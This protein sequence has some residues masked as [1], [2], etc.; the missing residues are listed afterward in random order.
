M[1]GPPMATETTAVTERPPPGGQRTG[2]AERA[3]I[4]TRLAAGAL[5][6]LPGALVVYFGFNGGGFFAGTPAFACLIVIQLLLL[7]VLLADHPFDGFSLRLA[8]PGLALAGFVAWVLLSDAWSHVRGRAL[9]EFDRDLL[10]LLLLVLFGITA[11]TRARIPWIVRGLAAAI[12]VVCGSGL[13]TRVLPHVWPISPDVANNRLGFPL[14]YWNALG[15]LAT[16]GI[17]LLF[18]LSASR[19]EPRGVRALACGAIPVL[20]LTLYFTFS[21]GA[22]AALMV[23]LVALVLVAR[24]NEIGGTL[25]AA[26]P[27]SVVAV[28]VAYHADK[29]ATLNPTTPAAVSQGKHVAVVAAVCIVAAILLRWALFRVDH[30]LARITLPPS[31]RSA[32]R[33]IALAAVGLALVVALAAGLQHW[34][35]REYHG[36]TKGTHQVS[37]QRLR[38]TDPSSNG[39]I[40]HW[41]VSWHGFRDSKLHGTGAGTYEFQWAQHRKETF[42]ATDGH[43]L[44]MEVLGELGIVGLGLL[45]VALGGIGWALFRAARRSRRMVY[46]ALFAAFVAWAVHAG[47]DWDWEMPAVT[48]WVFA[49]GGAALATRRSG[50]GRSAGPSGRVPLAA[51]LA[52]AAATPALIL[53]SQSHLQN[54][55]RAFGR[56]DCATAVH[57]ARSSIDALAV[58]PEPYQILGYCDLQQGRPDAA[59]AA[60]TK[61]SAQEPQKWEYHLGLA[62]AQASA[63]LD[64]R[65]EAAR[66]LQLNPRDAYT[67]L[68]VGSFR[69]RSRRIWPKLAVGLRNAMIASGELTL[70]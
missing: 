25:L 15:I 60:M 26:L 55:A 54:S 56:G 53:F 45:L 5:A 43:S 8:V 52:V 48:A 14:T 58:R 4:E 34:I 57:Q 31:V 36:F 68:A 64:P 35:S 2:Q 3:N 69:G 30:A 1:I 65:P 37:D 50:G 23:G 28:V 21:R 38:L 11:R 24:K 44:Y 61:A 67:R 9:I 29:L 51:A 66:A 46:A 33:P 62:I 41:T 47:V 40:D 6:L 12:V 10:Y 22:I 32:R 20:A 27:P 18:G 42:N 19:E 39:R 49:A 16:V 70:K 7:R 13:I 17:I 59:V 63:G